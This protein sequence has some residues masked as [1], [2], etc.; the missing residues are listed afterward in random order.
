[1]RLELL[2]VSDRTVN[3]SVPTDERKLTELFG[4]IEQPVR[5][6]AVSLRRNN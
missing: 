1:M 5:V 2:I 4:R 6:W 3:H